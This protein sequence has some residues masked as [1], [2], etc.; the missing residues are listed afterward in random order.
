MTVTVSRPAVLCW[1]RPPT[2]VDIG[3]YAGTGHRHGFSGELFCLWCF[4]GRDDWRHWLAQAQQAAE[5]ARVGR[6][7]D[8]AIARGVRRGHS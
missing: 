7:C 8:A 2:A 1:S 5:D 4:G 6:D 3:A